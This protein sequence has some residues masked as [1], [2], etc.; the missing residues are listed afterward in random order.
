MSW[1]IQTP[2]DYINGPLTV[3]G[4]TT[5]SGDLTAARWLITG[6]SL[7]GVGNANPFAYR[8]GGGGL[9]IGAATETGTTAPIIFYCG[10]GGVEQYR[11]A[12]LGI[13]T[14]SD[15]A[16]GTRM[17]LNATGLGLGV[18]PVTALSFPIG[19]NKVVG[20]SAVTSH[21]AGNAGSLKFGIADGG[22][23]YSGIQIFN[24]HN[25]TYS[26]QDIRFFTA[27]GGVSVSTERLRISPS[28]NLGL[29]V[30]PQSWGS[31]WKSMDLA[32]GGRLY[33]TSGTGTHG[34][35]FNGHNNNTNWV[36]QF[37]TVASRF[38]LQNTGVFA[39]F[40][41][42]SGTS[43]NAITFTQAMTLDSG[44]SLLLGTTS[45]PT[46][47]KIGSI[48]KLGGV[49]VEGTNYINV[50]T[51]PVA[52]AR[53]IGTGALFFVAG[54]NTTGGAQGWWLVASTGA[55]VATVIA[56]GNNT[57]LTVAF[58]QVSGVLNMNT[59]SG[60]VAV[61]AFSITN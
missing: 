40:T 7:P 4:A 14:W 32:G 46:G 54:Y 56:S 13:N 35:C 38:E 34:L 27:E 44:G 29:G 50:S 51:T 45:S 2:G 12:P 53:S 55:S 16:G 10:A 57:L 58:T 26:S 9:G 49:S 41:A 8:I 6:G 25:G 61:T 15:G 11:I 33:T 21:L 47:T 20:Q 59:T 42:P 52:L 31:N 19:T 23:D 24:T 30:N 39:W 43:G 36:Y 3:V 18:S 60:T 48:V 1:N 22:A 17:T 28:G 5:I 37:S